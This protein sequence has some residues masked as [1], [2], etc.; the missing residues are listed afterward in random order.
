MDI[1]SR[2]VPWTWWS[3]VEGCAK[4]ESFLPHPKPLAATTPTLFFPEHDTIRDTNNRG[5]GVLPLLS[6]AFL[7]VLAT[8]IGATSQDV[9]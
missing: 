1:L 5:L 9:A 6:A 8:M 7:V 3:E 4:Q 2:R